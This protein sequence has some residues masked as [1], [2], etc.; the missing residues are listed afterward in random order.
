MTSRRIRLQYCKV[1]I[2]TSMVW[3]MVDVFV[4]M[5]FTDC[6]NVSINSN[7]QGSNGGGLNANADGS[8]RQES[9]GFLD[10]IIPKG[11]PWLFVQAVS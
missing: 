8:N 3:V 9:K 7:C 4:L 1:I 5:Y 6:T 10:K 2:L 11:E